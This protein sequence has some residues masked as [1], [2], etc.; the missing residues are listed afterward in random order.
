MIIF[1]PKGFIVSH[2]KERKEKTCL[3]CGAQVAGRY[4][5]DCGQENVE[6]KESVW[7]FITHFFNDITHFDGKLLSTIKL[8][9]TKPGFL[10]SEYV[11]GKRV[12]YLNPIRM[13]LFLSFLLFSLVYLLPSTNSN[14]HSNNAQNKDSINKLPIAADT[15]KLINDTTLEK[16]ISKKKSYTI[17]SDKNGT[18]TSDTTI[19]QYVAEQ[20]ALPDNK[21]D[22]WFKRYA[23]KRFIIMR[24]Y[25]KKHKDDF[26]ND[27]FI[28]HMQHK[29]PQVLF[30]SIPI[31]AFILYLLYITKRKQYYFVSHGIFTLHLYS[32]MYLVLILTMPFQY[33][34]SDIVD[35]IML[36]IKFLIPTV[37]L[38]IAMKRFY[39]QNGFITFIKWLMVFTFSVIIF[40]VLGISLFINTLLDVSMQ[41]AK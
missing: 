1:I 20:N 19:A 13:Y 36:I 41:A 25:A 27:E 33:F 32:A 31:F 28:N 7:H 30:I 6:P 40:I 23:N 4:C 5:Q 39:K 8:L 29:I 37:Y 17:Y 3:N 35:N 14:N 10:S 15:G 38:F 9:I 34:N 2:F 26:V 18:I 24:S 12:K 11:A 21:K 22:G 16:Q